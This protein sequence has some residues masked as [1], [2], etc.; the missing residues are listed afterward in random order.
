MLARLRACFTTDETP[1]PDAKRPPR[2]DASKEHVIAIDVRGPAFQI[3]EQRVADILWEWQ[4]HLVSP[5]SHHL[6]RTVV[7]V[8]IF[9]S[10]TRYI[11]G[12]QS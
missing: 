2:S 11:S 1:S 12:S 4:S 8:D 5:F 6:K 10:Q 3:A 7:P 9:E